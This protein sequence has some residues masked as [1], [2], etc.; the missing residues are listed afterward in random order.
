MKKIFLTIVAIAGLATILFFGAKNI[1]V[2]FGSGGSLPKFSIDAKIKRADLILIGEVKNT[3][4]SQ[5]TGPNGSDP[6]NASPEDV[7]RANGLFTDSLIFI[8]QN[9]KGNI[10]NPIVRVRVFTGETAGVRWTGESEPDYVVGRTY[11]LFL[12]KDTGPTEKVNPGD[13]IAVGAF[14]GVYEII[15]GKAISKDDEWN[16]EELIAYI[17]NKL[18]ESDLTVTPTGAVSISTDSPEEIIQETVTPTP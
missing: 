12:K 18:S 1:P 13:Y 3:L 4:P 5:W 8:N 2:T 16:L 9:L 7:L 17:Q 10:K 14:Q 15:N 6:K 11:L